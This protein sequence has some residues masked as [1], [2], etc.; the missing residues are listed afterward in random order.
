MRNFPKL[1]SNSL[2]LLSQRLKKKAEQSPSK[3]RVSAI[4]FDRNG[5]FIAQAF[6]TLP[7]DG[8]RLNKGAGIHAEAKL[9]RKYGTLVKTIIISRIGRGGAWLPIQP[10]EKC[11]ELARKLGIKIVPIEE[12]S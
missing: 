5:D 12:C 4:A 6:N 3:T 2:G 11:Q 9:M 8:V 10:C 7:I 1:S